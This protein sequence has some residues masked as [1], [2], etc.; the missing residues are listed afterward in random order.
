MLH[1]LKSSHDVSDLLHELTTLNFKDQ[2]TKVMLSKLW[3][4]T[5]MELE[6]AIKNIVLYNTKLSIEKK[7]EGHIKAYQPYEKTWFKFKDDYSKVIV[8]CS[9][10]R[11]DKYMPVVID[12]MVYKK[13]KLYSTIEPSKLTQSCLIHYKCKSLASIK[14]HVLLGACKACGKENSLRLSFYD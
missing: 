5:T 10:I 8:E 11:C 7:I 6:P 9:C 13:R 2:N 14:P 4:E 3:D 1:V 12:T